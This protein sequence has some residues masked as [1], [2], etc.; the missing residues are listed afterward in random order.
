MTK[1]KNLNKEINKKKDFILNLLC[2]AEKRG[3][4]G[5]DMKKQQKKKKHGKKSRSAY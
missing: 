1:R 2:Y 4:S 5:Q 3:I